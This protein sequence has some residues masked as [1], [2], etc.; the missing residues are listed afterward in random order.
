M[1]RIKVNLAQ[2][3]GR[4]R[5]IITA[6]PQASLPTNDRANV[7]LAIELYRCIHKVLRASD[8]EISVGASVYH[9]LLIV[10]YS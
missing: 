9:I 4:S 6:Q 2:S 8:K 10:R 1:Q 5:V 3:L 7:Y